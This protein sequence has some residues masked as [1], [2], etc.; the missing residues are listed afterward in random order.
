MYARANSPIFNDV[1]KGGNHGY[2]AGKGWDPVTGLGWVDGQEMLN[3]M[4]I[5]QTIKVGNVLPFI[6]VF[7]ASQ[8]EQPSTVDS[9]ST[10]GVAGGVNVGNGGSG[11]ID[12]I[13]GTGSK[14]AFQKSNK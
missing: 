12:V 2:E 10:E 5:N 3:A 6:P 7:G 13:D 4:L 1:D 8:A 14:A 9:G 11:S